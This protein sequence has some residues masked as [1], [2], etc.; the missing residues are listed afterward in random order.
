MEKKHRFEVDESSIRLDLFLSNKLPDFSRTSIQNSIKSSL[1]KVNGLIS[2]AS[3][4]LSSGDI[5]ECEIKKKTSNITITPQNIPL[6]I[7]FE[8]KSIIVINKP[9]GLVVHPGSG[10]KDNTLVNG[11][12]YHYKKLS[13]INNLRPGIIHRLDKDTSGV[14]VIAKTDKAHVSISEQFANR[15]VKKTYYALA[16]GKVKDKGVIKGLIDRDSFNRTKFKMSPHKGRTS[17]TLYS[18]ENY[19]EPISL[20]KLHPETGRTHQIRVHLNSIG[21]PIFSDSQYSGGAKRIKSYHVKYMRTLKRL[22]KLMNRVALHAQKIN[23]NHPETSENI[24]FTA[25]F[26]DDFNKVLELLKN[27]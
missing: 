23:F 25:P 9:S 18:L 26:P 17:K 1:V 24:S 3:M 27:E 22:F 14:I 10:N 8:D 19:F 11:L 16:W 5:V 21:H 7:L 12:I 4:K 13:K 6:D 15:S 2:K 20:V